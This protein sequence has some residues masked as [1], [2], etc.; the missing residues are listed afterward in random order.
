MSAL[1]DYYKNRR[2][3]V[4]GHTGFKGSWLTHWLKQLGAQQCGIALAPDTEPSIFQLIHG[5]DGIESHQFD[6]ADADGVTRVMQSFRPEIVFH[7]AA[8][9]LVRRSYATPRQTFLSNVMGTAHVLEAVRAAPT[10]RAVLV[11][12]SDKVYRNRETGQAFVEDDPLG[13]DDPYSASKACA[14]ILTES[15]R[16]S[17]FQAPTAARVASARAGNVFGGGDWCADRLLPD[18]ARAVAKDVPVV[19]RNPAAVRPWQYVLEALSGYLMLGARLGNGEADFAQSWNFGPLNDDT[20]SV[21][22]FARQV[23]RIWGRGEVILRPD[24]GAPKEARILRLDSAKSVDRLGW[25]PVLPLQAAI[26]M[27]VDWYRTVLADP[28]RAPDISTEQIRTF[29][30]HLGAAGL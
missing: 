8:Q 9:S 26:E 29:R 5:A 19:L 28:A 20:L 10:V 13:G 25:K 24:P 16:R 2:V 23:V 12:T 22:D 21:A 6:L 1:F 30:A 14:E 7:L 18:I 17:F 15:W 27:S 4:T 3:L 11:V